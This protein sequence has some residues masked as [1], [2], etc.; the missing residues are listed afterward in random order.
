MTT[1]PYLYSSEFRGRKASLPFA[2]TMLKLDEM[3][4][5]MQM[6]SSVWETSLE[7]LEKM[8]LSWVPGILK[9]MVSLRRDNSC[10]LDVFVCLVHV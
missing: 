10:R 3:P 2:T 4:S 1:L 7:N 9:V 6:S 5:I 8:R